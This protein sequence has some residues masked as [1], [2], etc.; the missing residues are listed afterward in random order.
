MKNIK[1]LPLLLLSLFTSV[2]FM[3]SC[4]KDQ[5]IGGKASSSPKA[6]SISPGAAASNTVLTITGS[7]LGG[8]QTIM[9]DSGNVAASFNPVFNTDNAIIFRVP[10]EAIPAQQNIILTNSLGTQLV[11]PFQVLGLPTITDVSNYNWST[12]YPT[13]T[14][15]GKNLNDV[16]HVAF[17]TGTDTAT[18]VSQTNTSLVITL[19]A[20][21]VN[22]TFLNI[23]NVAG[24]VTTTQ[25]FIN[26]DNAFVLFDDVYENGF[27]NASW[28]SD[29]FVST[30]TFKSGTASVAKTY[31]KDNW[32]QLGFGWNNISDNG[33]TYLAFW[34]KGASL[35]Y[36]LWI[37]TATS[38]G[39]FASFNDYDKINVP[40]NVWTYFK[41]P[42]ASLKLWA[43]GSAWNQIGWR[44]QGPSG[45]NETFYLDDVMFVK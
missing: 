29:A 9:F 10:V 39:G 21:T 45:Q 41:L 40:A 18:I 28:G 35:D 43:T 22:H 5:Q 16:F 12:N 4:K 7:G 19:P 17:A 13:L 27:Q 32:H 3:Y 26:A 33:Y 14:L 37:S 2:V 25:E 15:T 34:I 36:P 8:I 30:T 6:D 42:V 38:E 23:S 1:N 44:I 11:I 31:D 24:T 20:S